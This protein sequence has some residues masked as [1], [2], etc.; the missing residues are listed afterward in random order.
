VPWAAPTPL[1]GLRDE[2]DRLLAQ[3]RARQAAG[4]ERPLNDP[5]HVVTVAFCG[6]SR[7]AGR[8]RLAPLVE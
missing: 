3:L 6:N 5:E 2:A 7:Q 4:G 1:R 8:S